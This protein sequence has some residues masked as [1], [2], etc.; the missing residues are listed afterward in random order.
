MVLLRSIRRAMWLTEA[1]KA[2]IR[3]KVA[4]VVKVCLWHPSRR[5][6]P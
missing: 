3:T 4:K 5:D 1:P 2:F 6:R